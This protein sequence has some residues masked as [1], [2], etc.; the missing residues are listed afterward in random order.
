MT[1]YTP[2]QIKRAY[3]QIFI[4]MIRAGMQSRRNQCVK[5]GQDHTTDH[6]YQYEVKRAKEAKAILDQLYRMALGGE[7]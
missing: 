4:P 1:E 7:V 2:D 5:M 6:L 3:T